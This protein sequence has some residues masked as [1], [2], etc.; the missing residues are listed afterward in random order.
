M[1]ISY[2]GHYSHLMSKRK[3]IFY[4]YFGLFESMTLGMILTQVKI[5]LLCCENHFYH[6]FE[7]Q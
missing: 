7:L 1:K 2:L 4:D 5:Y 3:S 6:D